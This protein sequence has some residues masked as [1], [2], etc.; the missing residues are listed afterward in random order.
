[1]AQQSSEDQDL[2]IIEASRSHSDTPQSL[3]L[4]WTSES[5]WCSDLYLTTHNTHNRTSMSQAGFEPVIPAS[6]Q[7]QTN[8]SEG[9]ASEI[10]KY[11]YILQVNFRFWSVIWLWNII[12]YA[13]SSCMIIWHGI[14][15]DRSSNRS[16]NYEPR[17]WFCQLYDVTTVVV[18]QIAGSL[19]MFFGFTKPDLRIWSS[20]GF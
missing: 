2:L 3:E 4:L 5:A 8:A 10:G 13:A 19:G 15:R 14:I 16:E 11:L 9:A 20:V 17:D 12:L 18:S 6:E 1:M 7:P